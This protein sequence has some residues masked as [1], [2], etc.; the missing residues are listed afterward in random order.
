MIIQICLPLPAEELEISTKQLALA[1]SWALMIQ[2]LSL[3]MA[4]LENSKALK[5]RCLCDGVYAVICSLGDSE[6]NIY[7]FSPVSQTDYRAQQVVLGKPLL[8]WWFRNAVS[9]VSWGFVSIEAFLMTC[10]K[11]RKLKVLQL[12]TLEHG[13][14]PFSCVWKIT[15]QNFSFS[16]MQHMENIWEISLAPRQENLLAASQ[17]NFTPDWV[18]WIVHGNQFQ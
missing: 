15:A 2:C 18:D 11:C 9:V 3:P 1:G 6:Q 7:I 12:C 10:R 16:C 5:V 13:S 17:S 14:E 8:K 4:D